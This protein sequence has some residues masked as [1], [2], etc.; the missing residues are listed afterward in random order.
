M[1][2]FCLKSLVPQCKTIHSGSFDIVGCMYDFMSSVLAPLNCLLATFLFSSDISHAKKKEYS[3][4]RKCGRQEKSSHGR[5]QIYFFKSIFLRYFLFFFNFFCFF[6][7]LAFFG[8]FVCFLKLNLY[9]LIQIR[10]YGR[11]SDKNFFT[12]PISGNKTTYFWRHPFTS[13]TTESPKITV[14]GSF[15]A[16]FD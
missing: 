9:I 3:F 13:F 8:L 16:V 1:L 7:I 12:Q 6:C 2:V 15:C 14:T 10:L 11:V 4:P 5:P